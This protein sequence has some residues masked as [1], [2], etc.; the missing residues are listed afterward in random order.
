MNKYH[1]FTNAVYKQPA[2]HKTNLHAAS[3]ERAVAGQQ[4]TQGV[5]LIFLYKEDVFI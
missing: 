3:C 5:G 1:A 4:V 2:K